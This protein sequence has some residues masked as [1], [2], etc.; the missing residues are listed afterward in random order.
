[1]HK[2]VNPYAAGGQIWPIQNDAK[3]LEDNWNPGTWVLIWEYSLRAIQWIPTRQGL[4]GFQKCLLSCSLDESIASIGRVKIH[5]LGTG[6]NL[7]RWS[8]MWDNGAGRACNAS[9]WRCLGAR[10]DNQNPASSGSFIRTAPCLD[11]LITSLADYQY[12]G[13]LP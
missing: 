5:D 12:G 6:I 11:R 1:M 3:I 7:I 4:D 10:K 8:D 2:W 9:K 13:S